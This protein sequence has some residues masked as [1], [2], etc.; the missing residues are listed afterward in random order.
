M[1]KFLTIASILILLA[2]TACNQTTSDSEDLIENTANAS[3]GPLSI[4]KETGV[5]IHAIT[6]FDEG[7][8]VCYKDHDFFVFDSEGNRAFDH[9][10]HFIY[11]YENGRALAETTDR[12]WVYIDTK[13]NIVSEGSYPDPLDKDT[14][15]YTSDDLPDS[16]KS[17]DE[18]LFGVVD[19]DG[20]H[21]TEPIFSWIASVDQDLNF[22]TLN[23]KD[24][25]SVM[26]TPT[27][28]VAV[29]LHAHNGCH[30]ALLDGE[31]IVCRHGDVYD[32]ECY[33]WDLEGNLLTSTPFST[34]G[35]F[36][37]G[38]AVITRDGKLGLIN[39]DGEIIVEPFL[40][41]GRQDALDPPYIY[42]NRIVCIS[43]DKLIF[44]E[45]A[46]DLATSGLQ[47]AMNAYYQFLRGEISATNPT[48]NETYEFEDFDWQAISSP[49]YAFFDVNGDQ[50]PE[51]HVR[52]MAHTIFSYQN[53]RLEY[54]YT[55]GMTLL[56]S[57]VYLPENGTLFATKGSD[58]SGIFY[59]YTTFASHGTPSTI[60]LSIPP[61]NDS[62]DVLYPY[63]FDGETVTEEEFTKLAKEYLALFENPASIEWLSHEETIQPNDT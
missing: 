20:N 31:N 8:V 50:I 1:K 60:S 39:S 36:Y 24:S 35:N 57:D 3:S 48:N 18:T 54:W 46:E 5:S 19:K 53:R 6:G 63:Y 58:S 41:V 27:G 26:I 2:F 13:G 4:Y 25:T 45:V 44:I 23:D 49:S 21:L 56:E 47:S 7:Y 22:A 61:Q 59:H 42:E 17:S 15:I 55:E 29:T 32:G 51:L 37:D 9:S 10:F 62:K 30:H 52:S 11:P 16:N 38:I 40:Y 14:F 34:I 28:E 43:D 12:K 33:L